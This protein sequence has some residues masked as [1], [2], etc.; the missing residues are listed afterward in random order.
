MHLILCPNTEASQGIPIREEIHLGVVE[1][2]SFEIATAKKRRSPKRWCEL[3]WVLQGCSSPEMLTNRS[4]VIKSCF[5]Q[6]ILEIPPK[7]FWNLSEVFCRFLW[8]FLTTWES[9]DVFRVGI[10]IPDVSLF[11]R[12][13]VPSPTFP[14]ACSVLWLGCSDEA[15]RVG[16]IHGEW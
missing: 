4:S 15:R 3:K 6:K 7:H 12:L 8:N 10:Q 2:E 13:A 5:S 9:I 14:S 16:E 1:V 11:H